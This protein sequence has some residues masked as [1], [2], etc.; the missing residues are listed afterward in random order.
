MNQQPGNHSAIQEP[1]CSSAQGL[2]AL[3]KS[4]KPCLHH[5]T[6][7]SSAGSSSISSMQSSILEKAGKNSPLVYLP[8]FLCSNETTDL[9]FSLPEQK[10]RGLKRACVIL[11]QFA[12]TCITCIFLPSLIHRHPQGQI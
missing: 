11:G 2:G 5:A 10:Q 6:T 7:C 1:F 9:S 3:G 8:L 4:R 12:C